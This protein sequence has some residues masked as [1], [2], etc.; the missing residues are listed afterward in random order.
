MPFDPEMIAGVK[1]FLDPVET[2]R[3]YQLGLE[4][5]RRGPCLEIGGYCGKST[6]C[7]GTACRENGAVLFSVDHH[8]G[9]EEQQPG[10]EYF[11]PELLDPQTGR[12]DTFRHFRQT[13]EQA[14]LEDTV[15]PMVCRSGLPAR[16]WSTP[17]GL[18]FIDGGHS[19]ADAFTDYNAWSGHVIAG[20]YLLI[21]DIFEDP[22]KGGQA[23]FRVYQRAV[24]SGLFIELPM[25][26]T[27]GVLQR[28]TPTSF[29]EEDE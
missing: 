14:G 3:L 11:D 1:G 12:L 22:A 5:S 28:R 20:G 2:A 6:V 29:P 9:S 15:V 24:S 19:F 17:L 4:A 16:A 25:T 26:G 18:V 27:L 8:R 13:L 10:E 7:L 21:H 23:P